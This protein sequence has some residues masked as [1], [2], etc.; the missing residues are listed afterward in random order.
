MLHSEFSI[1]NSHSFSFFT[2]VHQGLD[3]LQLWEITCD[4]LIHCHTS[5]KKVITE[6]SEALKYILIF[7]SQLYED[8]KITFPNPWGRV[9]ASPWWIWL[10]KREKTGDEYTNLTQFDNFSSKLSFYLTFIWD[11]YNCSSSLLTLSLDPFFPDEFIVIFV[12]RS[13][14]TLC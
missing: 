4:W 7:L 9:R 14:K 13:W 11:Y 8:T 3:F 1:Q 12:Q 2:H 6:S 5:Q 10:Q